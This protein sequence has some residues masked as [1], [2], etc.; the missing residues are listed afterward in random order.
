MASPE[1]LFAHYCLQAERMRRIARE[2]QH[3][4]ARQGALEVAKSWERLAVS[5]KLD[6]PMVRGWVCQSR[7]G[8]FVEEL[9]WQR[10]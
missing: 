3:G 9:K 6:H 4:A 8:L 1:D 2:M 5:L 7:T 10:T